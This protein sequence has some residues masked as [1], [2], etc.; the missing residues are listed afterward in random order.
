MLCVR[1][2][3]A[4]R[5]I[6]DTTDYTPPPEAEVYHLDFDWRAA[7]I[8]TNWGT[9]KPLVAN[10]M[11]ALRNA[12]TWKGLL[13]FDEFS[14]RT[15]LSGK[16]PWMSAAEGDQS[17]TDNH[18]V[19][20]AEWLQHQGICVHPNVAAQAVDAVAREHPFHPVRDYLAGLAWDGVPRL[21]TWLTQYLGAAD[22]PYT[23]AVG[24]RWM[25]S[26]IARVHEPG[27]KADCMLIL[28]GQ[29]GIYKSTALK[30]LGEP[31][32]TD[33]VAEFGS[34]DASMQVHGVWIVEIAE[35][36][37]LVSTRAELEKVKAF[38][39]R[40][41]DRF[42]P[43][44]GRRLAQFPRQCVFAGTVNKDQYLRDETGGRRF[45][46]VICTLIDIPGLSDA[47]DQLW[48]EARDRYLAGE[49]SWLDTAAL[50][51]DAREEQIARY[52]QDPWQDPISEY[53]GSLSDTSVSEIL[54][55]CLHLPLDRWDQ[56][57][58]NRVA[59]CLLSL[60]WERYLGPRP[61]RQW[62]YR[63]VSPLSPVGD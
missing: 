55:N 9:P 16:A 38:L 28:E 26:A 11:I 22:T 34:K 37:S 44:Y 41:Q 40:T 62:R 10:A 42:R 19:R 47:R 58:M 50:N 53:I 23:R 43:P 1:R 3:V 52:E 14:Q 12:P 4:R 6:A 59:R 5:K 24:S 29:Q 33:E 57:A 60:G 17:W 48:A 54:K 32:F 61:R 27:C 63:Q 7:L 13:R 20:A 25:I 45:W 39:S 18:D 56:K 49:A 21:D 2:S 51:N 46:P 15:I 30:T 35:L 31:W 36:S 8:K